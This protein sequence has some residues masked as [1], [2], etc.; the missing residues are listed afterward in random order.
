MAYKV[1][2]GMI[3]PYWVSDEIGIPNLDKLNNGESVELSSPSAQCSELLIS[4]SGSSGPDSSWTT[5]EIKAY[6]DSNSIAYKSSDSK[7]KLLV[8]ATA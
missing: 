2:P 6:M 1:I 5:K 4:D 3:V 8:K 7:A